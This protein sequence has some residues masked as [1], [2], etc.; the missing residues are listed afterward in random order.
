MVE[1]DLTK[2]RKGLITVLAIITGLFLLGY[3]YL[4]TSVTLQCPRPY[5]LDTF[6]ADDY[7]GIWY[8]L[9]RSKNI[10][11]EDGECVTA[12]YSYRDDGYIKVD[13]NQWYGWDGGED[14]VRGGIGQAW[15]NQWEA[16]KLFVSFFL[17]FGG[18]YRILDTDYTSYVVVYSCENF[19]ANAFLLTEYSW[20]L[21]RDS[22]ED[23]SPEFDKVM[24]KVDE[25]YSAKIPHY[26]HETLMRTTQHGPQCRYYTK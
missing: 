13:N 20:V 22:I 25:V 10:P 4:R 17:D 23:G 15:I 7:L 16:G 24:T 21:T 8:E 19:L 9:R 11:F 3:V 12:Q 1:T 2:S 26:D 5:L 18:K 14:R 6:N